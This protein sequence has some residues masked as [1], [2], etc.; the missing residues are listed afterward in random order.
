MSQSI[1][2]YPAAEK[3]LYSLVNYEKHGF[4]RDFRREYKI[5]RM[6]ELIEKSKVPINNLKVIHIA[7]TK[8]K[9]S[10]A[11]FISYILAGLGYKVGMFTS[12][13]L[14]SWR[15][16]I[17]IVYRHHRLIKD[18]LIEKKKFVVILNDIRRTIDNFYRYNQKV[19]FFEAILLISLKYFIEEKVD[20][21][22][23]E[24]GLGGR[25]DATNVLS[26]Q[27]C[28]ITPIDY[29]HKDI[30]GKTLKK[31]TYEKAGIIKKG[32]PVII[33][34]QRD[35]VKRELK[36]IGNRRKAPLYFFGKDFSIR[37]ARIHRN[38]TSF[39]FSSEDK[40]IQNL[41]VNIKGMF[42]IENIAV[43]LKTIEVLVGKD[44]FSRQETVIRETL[45]QLHID[46][47]F[48]IVK[49]NPLII[50]DIA[51]N[52]FSIKTL[53]EN[54]KI[55][56]PHKEII[57]IFSASSDKDIC[58][59]LKTINYKYLILTKFNLPRCKSPYDIA[60]ECRLKNVYIEDNLEKSLIKAKELYNSKSLIL[61]TGSAFI[62][63]EY[64]TKIKRDV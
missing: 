43:T 27:V 41:K 51:H 42:Q 30:L 62:V 40:K 28:V 60:K 23:I 6:R 57:L 18:K 13:H 19:S 36:K 61:I 37:N 58:K 3:Y 8:A 4:N 7:G 53:Y 25:L 49:K 45:N 38:Y 34:S 5:E 50:L 39:D 2:T 33:C 16:R 26:P 55:Y 22:V 35:T 14:I 56:Y 32:I 10:T 24:T 11:T 52:P 47:R 59:M 54:I 21:A 44:I 64:L 46:G 20:Y 1:T 9:G 29:D 15:E 63:G 12:P 48:Q 17:K 31:I